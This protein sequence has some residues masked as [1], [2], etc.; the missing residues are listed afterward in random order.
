MKSI[1][2]AFFGAVVASNGTNTSSTAATVPN[3]TTAAASTTV[4]A[5]TTSVAGSTTKKKDANATA[6]VA[7]VKM[8]MTMALPATVNSTGLSACATDSTKCSTDEKTFMDNMGKSVKE[9]LAADLKA[10]VESVKVTKFAAAASRRARELSAVAY[11]VEFEITFKGTAAQGDLESFKA[12]VESPAFATD[13]KAAVKTNANV[14]V[15]VTVKPV[16]FT[17]GGVAVTVAAGTTTAAVSASGASTVVPIA[18]VFLL[19]AKLA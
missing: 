19:I 4:A 1:F 17:D 5:S 12:A 13:F 8:E 6:F 7:A 11:D 9:S 10:L 18:A 2:F 3:T 15:E 16:T 14:D